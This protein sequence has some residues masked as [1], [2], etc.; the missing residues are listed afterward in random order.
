MV[1]Y[2]WKSEGDFCF[3]FFPALSLSECSTFLM[4]K[5]EREKKIDW[6]IRKAAGKL[7]CVQDER[8]LTPLNEGLFISL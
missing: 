5:R 1:I 4:R 7:G 3:A 8:S 2:E 6:K